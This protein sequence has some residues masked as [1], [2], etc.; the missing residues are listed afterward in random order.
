MD[1][2]GPQSLVLTSGPL[3]QFH[4]HLPDSQGR[5]LDWTCSSLTVPQMPYMPRLWDQNVPGSREAH[6]RLTNVLGDSDDPDWEPLDKL[7]SE[8]LPTCPD[9]RLCIG[10]FK[11]EQT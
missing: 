2:Q 8:V 4:F 3:G 5:G 1:R 7:T 6:V 10:A 11:L 9:L